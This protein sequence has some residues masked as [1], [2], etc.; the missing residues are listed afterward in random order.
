M[1]DYR[2]IMEKYW[3]I[4][5]KGILGIFNMDDPPP[6]K[7][8]LKLNSKQNKKLNFLY[9]KINKIKIP[10]QSVPFLYLQPGPEL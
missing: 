7:K 9:L 4:K 2:K 8:P 3:Q 5:K 1:S 6:K 10:W